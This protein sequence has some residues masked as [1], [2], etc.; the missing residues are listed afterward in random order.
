MITCARK[1]CWPNH[2]PLIVAISIHSYGNAGDSAWGVSLAPGAFLVQVW[3]DQKGQGV[4]SPGSSPLSKGVWH[5]YLNSSPFW[6]PGRMIVLHVSDPRGMELQLSSAANYTFTLP[7][8]ASFLSCL[9]IHSPASSGD[10]FPMETMCTW[11]FISS[12]ASGGTPHKTL[13]T[14][15]GMATFNRALKWWWHR[16]VVSLCFLDLALIQKL[17]YDIYLMI[18]W[19]V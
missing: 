15:H 1:F 12:C 14:L 11:K 10:H 8:T 3:A 4:N 7:L 18:C 6:L 17:Y 13:C 19:N 9:L 5:L 16:M 2:I